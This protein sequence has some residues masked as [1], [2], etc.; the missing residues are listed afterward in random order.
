MRQRGGVQPGCRK[1]LQAGLVSRAGFAWG[2]RAWPHPPAFSYP[3]FRGVLSAFP[4]PPGLP[5]DMAL[6]TW[7]RWKH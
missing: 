3:L 5:S 7:L 4:A 6:E 1:G 2:L